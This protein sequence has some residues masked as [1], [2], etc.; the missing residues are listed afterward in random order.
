MTVNLWQAPPPATPQA[1]ALEIKRH[2]EHW[3]QWERTNSPVFFS[4]L[5]N[6]SNEV[7]R[8]F[9]LD[10]AEMLCS[11]DN[12]RQ[13]LRSELRKLPHNSPMAARE[14]KKKI[15]RVIKKADTVRVL[16]KEATKILHQ[17]YIAETQSKKKT[18][19]QKDI[20]KTQAIALRHSDHQ[21]LL[22]LESR[23]DA[24]YR[25]DLI[26][27]F[28]QPHNMECICTLARARALDELQRTAPEAGIDPVVLEEYLT[29]ARRGVNRKLEQLNCDLDLLN[30]RYGGASP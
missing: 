27:A 13:L 5:P 3:M 6:L 23:L 29:K 18:K 28:V 7:L 2:A 8:S 17:R 16:R 25:F 1:L 9:K 4:D 11:L 30:I 19:E 24:R 12:E 10:T 22:K 20:D 26:E 14:V 15:Q 21:A